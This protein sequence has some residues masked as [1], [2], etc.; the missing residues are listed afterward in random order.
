M[1]PMEKKKKQ[2]RVTEK[3]NHADTKA[4]KGNPKLNGPNRP[5]T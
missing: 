1:Q 2:N 5:S 3:E 4:A